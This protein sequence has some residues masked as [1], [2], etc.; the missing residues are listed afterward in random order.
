MNVTPITP[1]NL[2]YF[3]PFLLPESAQAL[4]ENLPLAAIG[5]VSEET[6]CG[7]LTGYLTEHYFV[8]SSFF[9]APDYRRRGGGTLMLETLKKL[10]KSD[11][12]V[13]AITVSYT[14]TEPDHEL[15]HGFLEKRGFAQESFEKAIYGITLRELQLSPFFSPS[16]SKSEYTPPKQLQPFS[17]VP[18]LYIK[19]LD[20]R[21]TLEYGRPWDTP[22]EQ[23]ENLE[24]DL[25]FAWIAHQK[26]TAFLLLQRTGEH[27]LTL[28]YADAGAEFQTPPT[29]LPLMLKASF[30]K[31]LEKYSADTRLLIQ[32]TNSES[33]ALLRGLTEHATAI[34]RT[35]TLSILDPSQCSPFFE[36]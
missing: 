36:N 27:Q 7:A 12:E 31:A 28:A 6:G 18:E 8:I 5:L 19:Q 1:E 33:T 16:K 24:R 20:R 13:H 34:S 30:Q 3:K 2:P 35:A 9:V 14:I 21:I 11:P 17:K 23:A 25:S 22:L 26:I 15:L 29:A 4:E 32:T 10:L